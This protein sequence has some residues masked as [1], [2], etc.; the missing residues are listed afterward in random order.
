MLQSLSYIH[1]DAQNF[2][3]CIF[4]VPEMAYFI[5][6][7]KE[8]SELFLTVISDNELQTF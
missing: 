7:E 8:I 1:A 3:A 2:F 4:H 5:Q 6:N